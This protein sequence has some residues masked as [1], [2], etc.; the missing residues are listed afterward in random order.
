MPTTHSHPNRTGHNDTNTTP[1]NPLKRKNTTIAPANKHAKFLEPI[2]YTRLI[3]PVK[4]TTPDGEKS[5]EALCDTG[6]NVFV[7]DQGWPANNSIFQVQWQH[8][9]KITG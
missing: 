6:S 4:L 2:T 9:L 5:A 3:R 7:L 1:P 8:Q